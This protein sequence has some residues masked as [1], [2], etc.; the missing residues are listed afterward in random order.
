MNKLRLDYSKCKYMIISKRDIDSLL[1]TLTLNNLSIKRVNCIQYIGVLL[2]DKLSWK[3]HIQQLHE[4]L[5]KI[6]GL[7]FRLRHNVP[8]YTRKLVYY[9]TFQ[10][11]LF[12][13]LLNW[14][15]AAKSC[16]HQLEVLQKEFI[17]ASLFSPQTTTTNL[18]YFKF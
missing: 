6:C 16:L 8:L 7:I 4:K 3:Y 14:G 13:S 12:Y 11:T 17:R 1:F 2:D 9:S 5:S 15:R 10:S 18:L